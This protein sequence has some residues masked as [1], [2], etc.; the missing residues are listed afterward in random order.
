MKFYHHTSASV[1]GTRV[2]AA[3][4]SYFDELGWELTCHR[5]DA[6]QLYSALREAGAYPAGLYAQTSMRIEKRFLAYGHDFSVDNNPFQVGLQF[7]IDWNTDFLGR[8]ALT[9]IR[10]QTPTQRLVSIV[11]DDQHATPLG[12]EP[13]YQ[14]DTLVGGTTSAS[15]GHRVGLPIALARL[16]TQMFNS[17]TEE[18]K[19]TIDTAGT[20]HLGIVHHRPVFDPTGQRM[21]HHNRSIA[22]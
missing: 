14:G 18:F 4:L 19:V 5:C 3:R 22:L 17:P 1:A 12:N 7:A 6:D 15:F 9:K 16:N 20:H 8:N 11:L 2:R 13:V 21:R 10:G